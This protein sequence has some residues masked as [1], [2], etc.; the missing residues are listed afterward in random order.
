MMDYFLA[1]C[2]TYF[3]PGAWIITHCVSNCCSNYFAF[4]CSLSA[5]GWLPQVVPVLGTLF[6]KAPV[7]SS[8]WARFL[9]QKRIAATTPS[10]PSVPQ[11][12]CT[13]YMDYK[14][15]GRNQARR[16]KL[17]YNTQRTTKPNESTI[18]GSGG[19]T[20]TAA[21][22]PRPTVLVVTWTACQA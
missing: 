5:Q 10:L 20:E 7:Q 6:G 1:V 14:Y 9:R 3:W 15:Q 18:P 8:I 19:V 16:N 12:S 21:L 4:C 22:N 13:R 11:T 2:I 17:I